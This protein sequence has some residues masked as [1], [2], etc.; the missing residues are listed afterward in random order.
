MAGLEV[1]AVSELII[2]LL[3]FLWRTRRCGD[4]GFVVSLEDL[5]NNLSYTINCGWWPQKRMKHRQD[6][7][8]FLTFVGRKGGQTWE[9]A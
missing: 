3:S 8:T 1:A 4:L 9:E 6:I 2:F 5:G 7:T